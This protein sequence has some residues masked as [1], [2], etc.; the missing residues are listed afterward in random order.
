MQARAEAP[1]SLR[2]QFGTDKT[3]NACHGSDAPDTAAEECNFWFGPG[4]YPGKCDL[5]AGTTLCL[6]KP[7]LVADGAAGLVIDLI[8]ESFEVTAGGLYNLDRNAAAE[9]RARSRRGGRVG[10]WGLT[11]NQ[12]RKETVTGRV[13]VWGKEALWG[14]GSG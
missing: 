13:G 1:G 9:V 5:A 3:F 11:L 2:A 4:R 8:Q 12:S 6:V 7:H 10:V 14:A